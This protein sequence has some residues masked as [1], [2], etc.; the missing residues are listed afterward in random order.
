MTSAVA[1]SALRSTLRFAGLLLAAALLA[2]SGGSDGPVL[3]RGI[4]KV[5]DRNVEVQ[6]G[7]AAPGSGPT[8]VFEAGEG[9]DL[10]VWYKVGPL[11]AATSP[12][13]LYSRAGYGQS[14]AVAGTRDGAAIVAE[15]RALLGAMSVPLPVVLVA[16][17]N[18]SAYAELWAKTTP[19]EFAGLVLVEPRHRDFDAQC[20]AQ[21][22]EDC[23]VLGPEID[24]LTEPRRSEQKALPATW[25][26][27]RPLGGLGAIPLRVLTGTGQRNEL[28]QWLRLW[29][30]FHQQLAQESSKGKWETA[31]N[32]G[33]LVQITDA[34]A[35]AAAVAEVIAAK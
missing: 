20:A 31:G 18:S 2:S 19:A 7:G 9:D 26:A 28:D 17:G 35:I 3:V 10:G 32:S 25:D 1:A 6:S 16:H 11:V 8:V 15:L 29:Q 24:A 33:H 12:V 21:K 13:L 4:V 34:P 23:D 30:S 22:L 27:L 5:G 14:A